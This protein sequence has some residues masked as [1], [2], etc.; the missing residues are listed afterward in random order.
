ML[1]LKKSLLGLASLAV[2]ASMLATVSAPADASATSRVDTIRVTVVGEYPSVSLCA[3]KADTDSG[4]SFNYSYQHSESI[5][6]YLTSVSDDSEEIFVG[7]INPSDD[8]AG[9][10]SFKLDTSELEAKDYVLTAKSSSALGYSEDS[11]AFT[12]APEKA[13]FASASVP[14]SVLA[15]VKDASNNT[16]AVVNNSVTIIDRVISGAIAFGFIVTLAAI[17]INKLKSS[18]HLIRDDQLEFVDKSKALA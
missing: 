17:A 15:S 11:I 10:A 18:E 2:S 1:N 16:A 5:D 7:H 12:V 8:V 14:A 9:S 3:T 6:F 13:K 4:L